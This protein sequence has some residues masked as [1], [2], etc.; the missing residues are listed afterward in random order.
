MPIS[1]IGREIKISRKGVVFSTIAFIGLLAVLTITVWSYQQL[2]TGTGYTK[3]LVDLGKADIALYKVEAGKRYLE[4]DL[5]FST[6]QA[7]LDVAARGGTLDTTTYWYCGGGIFPPSPEEVNYALENMSLDFLNS[8]IKTSREKSKLLGIAADVENY[9]C[10]NFLDRGMENCSSKSSANCEDFSSK[11]YG[12]GKISVQEGAT[13]SSPDELDAYINNLRFYWIYYILR[14]DTEEKNLQQLID[15]ETSAT[16]REIITNNY[17]TTCRCTAPPLSFDNILRK[18]CEHY[19]TLFDQYVSCSYELTCTDVGGYRCVE[20]CRQENAIEKCDGN[21]VSS[22]GIEAI[23]QRSGGSLKFKISLTDSKFLVPNR[24]K[25]FQPLVWNV[26][27]ALTFADSKVCYY[28]PPPPPAPVGVGTGFGPGT[29]TATGTAT[30]TE[31]EP[32][33]GGGSGPAGTGTSG[34]GGPSS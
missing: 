20:D 11:A 26:W 10:V 33:G 22:G 34:P 6:R 4:N 13:V 29:Q 1:H 7:S 21:S 27:F 8:Y 28:N 2:T 25:K 16:C 17:P 12:K 30:A 15:A 14:K 23:D 3:S 5:I 32:T 18:V 19:E 31:R 9:K 24:N